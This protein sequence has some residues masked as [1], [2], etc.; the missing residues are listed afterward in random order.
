MARRDLYGTVPSAAQAGDSAR[1]GSKGC[2]LTACEDVVERTVPK[3]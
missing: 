2:G 1:L 3:D